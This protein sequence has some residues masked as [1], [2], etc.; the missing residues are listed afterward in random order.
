MRQC[1]DEHADTVSRLQ[2][3][4]EEDKGNALEIL[5]AAERRQP[6]RIFEQRSTGL[7]DRLLVQAVARDECRLSPPGPSRVALR[8]P[9]CVEDHA[10][11]KAARRLARAA[12]PTCLV[13]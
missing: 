13:S 11:R 2:A 12:L 4:H 10:G 7:L 9:T 3:G 1:V 8:I 5:L 6:P